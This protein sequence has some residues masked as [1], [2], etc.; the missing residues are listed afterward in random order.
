MELES[1]TVSLLQ[2]ISTNCSCSIGNVSSI[3][4][5]S[6]LANESDVVVVVVGIANFSFTDLEQVCAQFSSFENGIWIIE[7]GNLT[8]LNYNVTSLNLELTSS[9][10]STTASSQ[11]VAP[12]SGSQE[13]VL[14]LILVLC[15][16][17][18]GALVFIIIFVLCFCLIFKKCSKG[19]HN[20]KQK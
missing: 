5:L 18:G 14:I 7:G 6:C 19:S 20:M 12:T 16:T 4:L 3:E 8:L 17:A 15:G 13:F 9:C 2:S 11:T 1:A 10:S